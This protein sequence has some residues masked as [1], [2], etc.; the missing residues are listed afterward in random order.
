MIPELSICIATYDKPRYLER[1]LQS[2]VRQEVSVPYEII[3]A[4]DSS[5]S[6]ETQQVCQTLRARYLRIEGEPAYGNPAKARNAAYKAARGNVL[7]CQSD[8]VEHQGNAISFLL[9]I[10]NKKSNCFALATVVN[11][12]WD[13]KPVQKPLYTFV[14]PNQRRPLF[15]LGAV[16]RKHVYAIG[17]NDEGFIKQGRD[18]VFFSQ[19][20]I[21][22]QG[23]EPIYSP[24]ALG[25][26]LDHPR[27]DGAIASPESMSYYRK[28]L[29]E[30]QAGKP[31]QAIGGPWAYESEE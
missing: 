6:D 30:I 27:P 29:Q 22:G 26:H 9:D 20:L 11:V 25:H 23:L 18:D 3:V 2:I 4:D 28:R 13:G 12:S 31:W 7:I 21:Y 16:L 14:G 8:D 5:P 24:D 10:L 1:V 17:G 15:F 19:C